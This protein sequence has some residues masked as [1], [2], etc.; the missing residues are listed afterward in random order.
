MHDWWMALV[1]ARFGAVGWTKEATVLYRQHRANDT[2]AKKWSVAYVVGRAWEVAR[3]DR[4]VL[5]GSL[6]STQRQAAA[7]GDRYGERLAEKE[8]EIIRG[9]VSLR[10]KGPVERKKFLL[11][12]RLLKIGILRNVAW[13]LTA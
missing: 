6:R 7:F 10:E 4:Q 3:G 13:I 2:G 8:R 9:Y 1:G 5:E 11:A 12:N